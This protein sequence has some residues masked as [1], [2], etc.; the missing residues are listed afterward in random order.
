MSESSNDQPQTDATTPALKRAIS[1][2]ASIMGDNVLDIANF[3]IAKYEFEN[4]DLSPEVREEA[5]NRMKD[6]MWQRIEQAKRELERRRREGLKEMFALADKTLR[7]VIS[8][9]Q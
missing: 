8:R 5:I 3:T 9:K 2:D 4:A 1:V 6:A 7:E